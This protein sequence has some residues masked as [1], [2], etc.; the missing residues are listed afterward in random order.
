MYIVH[1]A[2]FIIIDTIV[3]NLFRVCPNN[4]FKVF[5]VDIHS[6]I[7]YPY[8]YRLGFSSF[9]SIIGFLEGDTGVSCGEQVSVRPSLQII[10]VRF[11][12]NRRDILT[13]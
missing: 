3:R 11:F 10:F 5:V 13:F 4:R 2:I 6:R 12:T 8:D 1:I 7:H 9:K